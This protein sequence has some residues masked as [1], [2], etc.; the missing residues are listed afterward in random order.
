MPLAPLVA[1][2]RQ[3]SFEEL[4]NSLRALERE[5]TQ[6]VA[7]SNRERVQACRQAVITAKDHARWVARNP[8]TLEEKRAQKREMILW[9]TTWLE[10]PGVFPAWIELRK[11]AAA[12][13]P[14]GSREDAPA[15]ETPAG[16]TET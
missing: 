11:R 16:E 3:D 10:N 2:V 9:I 1:G 14:G 4:E 7:A 15:S 12:E 6:A 5:Y 13:A 8:K